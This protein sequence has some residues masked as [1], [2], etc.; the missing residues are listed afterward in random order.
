M[1]LF[2]DEEI[3][4]VTVQGQTAPVPGLSERP[5]LAAESATAFRLRD[6][7]G[8]RVGIA[9]MHVRHLQLV[10]AHALVL[11]RGVAPCSILGH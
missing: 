5:I 4:T 9:H 7:L 8:R 10:P 1:G 3:E 11:P 2:S 6:L